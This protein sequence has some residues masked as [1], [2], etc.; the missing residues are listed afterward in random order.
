MC[1]SHN[2]I[3]F[4]DDKVLL[5]RSAHPPAEWIG[6]YRRTGF[7]TYS[8]DLWEMDT[9]TIHPGF[10]AVRP[11]YSWFLFRD[12]SWS[13]DRRILASPEQQQVT[14]VGIL[15]CG[16]PTESR[17]TPYRSE[18]FPFKKFVDSSNG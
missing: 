17:S 12:P 18:T 7:G 13:L 6:E 5:V 15:S 2:F 9:Q 4:E 1:D 8:V 10:V 16:R 11:I 3:R 14:G